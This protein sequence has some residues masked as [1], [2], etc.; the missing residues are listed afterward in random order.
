[1]WG[2][3]KNNKI[4]QTNKKLNEFQC[5]IFICKLVLIELR[6]RRVTGSH[7]KKQIPNNE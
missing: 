7:P 3:K 5:I 6:F 2:K 4:K 1:M